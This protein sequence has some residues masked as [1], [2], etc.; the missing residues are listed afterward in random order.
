MRGLRLNPDWA[1][2]QSCQ[3]LWSLQGG[4]KS[5]PNPTNGVLILS[6]FLETCKG[7]MSTSSPAITIRT[8]CFW[9]TQKVPLL[10]KRYRAFFLICHAATWTW[11]FLLGHWEL[12][13]P[14]SIELHCL[15]APGPLEGYLY[16]VSSVN[17]F[18][19]HNRV[20]GHWA[21]APP[22]LLKKLCHGSKCF[23]EPR[24]GRKQEW[25]T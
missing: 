14:H 19:K 21:G 6:F 3:K 22:P 2:F 23:C 5:S 18:R 12:V 10:W 15:V 24:L 11:C 9:E 20:I 25:N 16:H 8:P 13:S 17:S 4:K 1:C 7:K